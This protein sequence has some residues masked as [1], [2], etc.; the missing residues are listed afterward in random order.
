[1][2]GILDSGSQVVALRKEIA[3]V[4]QLP[5]EKDGCVTMETANRGKE[6]TEGVVHNCPITFAGVTVHLPVQIVR[7]MAFDIIL[8]RPFTCALH[9]T[10]Q[11]LPNGS[12]SIE[13]VE[14]GSGKR[15]FV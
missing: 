11:D 4:L 13:I 10:T 8:G 6:A 15:T 9:A 12:Q 5:I 3:E 2:E 14:P 7:N 1:I